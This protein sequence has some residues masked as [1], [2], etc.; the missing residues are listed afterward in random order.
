MNGNAASNSPAQPRF[1]KKELEAINRE[2][3]GASPTEILRWASRSF[4]SKLTFATGFGAEG[5]VLIDMIA[6]ADLDVDLFTL[7]TGLFFQETYD[8]WAK[9]EHSTGL[10]IRGVRP[11]TTLEQQSLLHGEELWKTKPD[12]CCT[13]RKVLPLK[14]ALTG[15][16]AWASAIR[17]D[18]TPDRNQTPIVSFDSKFSLVKVSPLINWTFQDVLN[19]IERHKV[20]INPL[21]QQ[22]YPSIGCAPCTSPVQA[23]EDPRAG[24]WRS[25][26]KTECGL[27]TN[28]RH[29]T[30]RIIQ[31]DAGS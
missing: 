21:H 12:L 26:Q 3:Q 15:F 17:R 6:R 5:C 20:P 19:Y 10:T 2:L 1:D 13:I 4:G 28:N 23:G 27:H 29:T 22:G 14:E 31:G 9:L 16:E 8:L 11:S 30:L 24:R 25:H 7:D 18:Q